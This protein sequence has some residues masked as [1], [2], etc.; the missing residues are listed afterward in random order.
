VGKETKFGILVHGSRLDEGKSHKMLFRNIFKIL[1]A[2]LF[3]TMIALFFKIKEFFI[4]FGIQYREKLFFFNDEV[5]ENRR[6]TA[7]R[8]KIVTSGSSLH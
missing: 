5:N 8:I 1:N 6:L 3:I 4:L 2:C 7:G